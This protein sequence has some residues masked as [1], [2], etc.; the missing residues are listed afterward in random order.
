MTDRERLFAYRRIYDEQGSGELFAAAMRESVDHHRSRCDFYNRLLKA[1]R[2]SSADI[3]TADDCAR[4][5]AIPA[6]FF[7]YHEALSVDREKVTVHAT[8]SGTQGQRSQIFLDADTVA[9]GTR[10]I[11]RAMRYH[12]LVSPLP[13]HY[14]ILGYEPRPGNEMGNIK[15]AQGMTRFAPALHRVYALRWAGGRYELDTI[16]MLDALRRFER[17]GLPVRILGF[18]SYLYMLLTAMERT[19]MK[20]LRLNRRSVILTGGGW[21]RFDGMMV[22]E[23]ELLSLVEERLGIPAA[24]CRDFY[25]AVEHSVAYPQCRNHHMH[26]PIW[27]RVV[28][29]DVRTL[30]PLGFDRPGLLSFVSPLVSSAPLSSVIMGDLAT[31]RDGRDC[32]C[33]IETPYFEIRAR[34]G[35]PAARSCAVAASEFMKGPV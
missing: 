31:L 1:R 7:K 19:G 35:A 32:G 28:I 4:I 24:R 29:R 14:L 27:S 8:S 12:G 18:P 17:T 5:P 2:F 26:V 11:V 13:A 6:S 20:P 34:A 16:G 22:K 33:G 23:S 9:L 30:E 15:V 3:R 21:K 10:M 25:S